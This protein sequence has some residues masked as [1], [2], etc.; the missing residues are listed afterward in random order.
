MDSSFRSARR[1]PSKKNWP[2]SPTTAPCSKPCATVRS[3]RPPGIPG[4]DTAT[5]SHNS[6]AAA[7]IA[8]EL[9]HPNSLMQPPDESKSIRR[10]IW[11]YFWLLI[12]E[13]ALRKWV[14][15]SLSSVLLLARDPV[16]IAI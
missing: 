15:P 6:S 7:A 12:F 8:L 11:L 14:V 1:Q 9:L 13:G 10:L 4:P 5:G 16:V 3:R 2:C